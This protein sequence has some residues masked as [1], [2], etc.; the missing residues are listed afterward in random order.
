MAFYSDYL[1]TK[2]QITTIKSCYLYLVYVVFIAQK[3]NI[4]NVFFFGY[5][6]L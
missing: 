4:K 3:Y 2:V 1:H 6:I 5:G